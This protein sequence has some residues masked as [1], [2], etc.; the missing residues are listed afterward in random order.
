MVNEQKRERLPAWSWPKEQEQT[1]DRRSGSCQATKID[2]QGLEGEGA[3]SQKEKVDWGEVGGGRWYFTYE[4]ERQE[5]EPTGWRARGEL[6]QDSRG[7]LQS[8]GVTLGVGWSGVKAVKDCQLRVGR[9][10]GQEGGGG[11]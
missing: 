3:V 6:Q 5:S 4:R 10:R 1:L 9:A 8:K 11:N 7:A 2:A